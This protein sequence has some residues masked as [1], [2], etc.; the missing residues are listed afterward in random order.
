MLV[1][2]IQAKPAQSITDRESVGQFAAVFVIRTK[3]AIERT[4]A[5]AASLCEYF[6]PAL[7]L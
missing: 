2:L 5:S 7:D 3:S 1:A 6:R 4:A